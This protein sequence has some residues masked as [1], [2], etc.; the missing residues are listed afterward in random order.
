LRENDFAG[1]RASTVGVARQQRQSGTFDAMKAY[2]VTAFISAQ[3]SRTRLTNV[4]HLAK[5]FF[6]ASAHGVTSQAKAPV[7]SPD[8][9]RT[10]ALFMIALAGLGFRS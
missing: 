6:R 7:P 4:N 3:R 9:S 8:T 1:S 5:F 10:D 2:D